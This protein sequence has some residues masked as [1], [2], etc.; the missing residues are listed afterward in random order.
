MREIKFRGLHY[1]PRTKESKWVYGDL[2]RNRYNHSKDTVIEGFDL[3]NK[4]ICWTIRKPETVGQLTGLKDKNGKEIYE[5]DILR[6]EKS[7]YIVKFME[8][9]FVVNDG[10]GDLWDYKDVSEVIGNI[11]ENPKLMKDE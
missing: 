5:G 7:T 10:Q 3:M 2:V 6:Y 4:L 8:G 9:C 1:N 11:Y